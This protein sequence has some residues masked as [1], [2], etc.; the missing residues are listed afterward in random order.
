MTAD[1]VV[2]KLQFP[3]SE[4]WAV[5]YAFETSSDT[6]SLM[7]W[8]KAGRAESITVPTARAPLLRVEMQELFD[9]TKRLTPTA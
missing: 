8:S 6:T 1:N 3:L 9:I 4:Y 2:A 5:S 7:F